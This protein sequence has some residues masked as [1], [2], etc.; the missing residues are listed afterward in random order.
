[1][2]VLVATAVCG[3]ASEFDWRNV[4]GITGTGDQYGCDSSE[5][6]VAAT[7]FETEYYRQTATLPSTSVQYL[8]D[9]SGNLNCGQP[10]Y[11]TLENLV[12]WLAA[13]QGAFDSNYP[14][15]GVQNTNNPLCSSTPKIKPSTA[16]KVSKK[17]KASTGT[18]KS[19]IAKNP[20][21]AMTQKDDAYRNFVGTNIYECSSN[22]PSDGSLNHAVVVIGYTKNTDWIVQESWGTGWGSGGY[23]TLKKGKECGLRTRIY[24]YN[25]GMQAVV[26]VLLVLVS[27]FAF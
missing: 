20:V 27:L 8:L 12:N 10:T 13:N 22:S 9:C 24:R 25:F 23:A 19:W 1:M 26:T 14:Y 11:T 4:G 15:T 5:G 16:I 6:W 18:M 17:H 7:M 21:G 3:I 2:T